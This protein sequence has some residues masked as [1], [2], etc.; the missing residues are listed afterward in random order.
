MN[1]DKEKEKENYDFNDDFENSN[2]LKKKV[3]LDDGDEKMKIVSKNSVIKFNGDTSDIP[4]ADVITQEK[5][6]GKED[7][8]ID[9]R[10]NIQF[11]ILNIITLLMVIGLITYSFTRLFIGDKKI[12]FKDFL[13][14]NENIIHFQINIVLFYSGW[15][16]LISK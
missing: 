12:I 7:I 9:Y 14:V 15:L 4:D 3:T 16:I 8:I 1:E 10:N 13:Q 6:I 5:E 11:R 2:F